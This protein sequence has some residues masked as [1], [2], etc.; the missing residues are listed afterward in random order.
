MKTCI[1]QSSIAIHPKTEKFK[2]THTH[3]DRGRNSVQ[4][5]SSVIGHQD[6]TDTTVHSLG[7]ILT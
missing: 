3:T 5:P 7:S 1:C 4:L 6:A 2:R